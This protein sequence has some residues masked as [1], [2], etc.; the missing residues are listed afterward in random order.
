[1]NTAMMAARRYLGAQVE[2]SSP[3]E[4]VVLMY[5]AALGG[6]AAAREA[7]ARRD[8]PARRAAMSKTMAIVAELQA[9][10]EAVIAALTEYDPARKG[11]IV[12][13]TIDEGAQYRVGSVDIESTIPSLGAEAL[14]S[15]SRVNRG[16][17]Y[18]AEAVEKSIEE[19]TI[20]ASR[21]GYPF[22]TVRPRGERNRDTQ[23][24]SVVFVVAFL[25]ATSSEPIKF[26]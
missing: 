21:M 7:M 14:R 24:V 5:D 26:L 25:L 4:R 16:A 3:T 22:A 8:I 2:S 12:T 9:T 20:Q 13:F 1:M 6:L 11:F 15:Y 23:T 19:M 18:N 17:I 10:L